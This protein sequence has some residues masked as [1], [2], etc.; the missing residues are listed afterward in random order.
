[1]CPVNDGA[2]RR[3]AGA[4]RARRDEL[5]LKQ[6]ELAT[7]A[8]ISE[9]TV[10]VIEGARRRS[11]Q[12]ATLRALSQALGWT[13]DSA[14]RILEGQDPEPSGEDVPSASEEMARLREELQALRSEVAEMKARQSS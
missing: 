6:V 9:P 1:M 12:K 11:Y 13:P 2:W 10:R 5:G 4:V 14:D 7:K 3:L 8:G